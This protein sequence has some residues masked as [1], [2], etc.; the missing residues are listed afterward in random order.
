MFEVK[1]RDGLAR[2]AE[3]T[4]GEETVRLPCVMDT[5]ILFP[6]LANRSFSN[7]P[8]AAPESFVA[9][10]LTQSQDQPVTVHPAIPAKASSGDCVM[11]ANWNTILQNPRSY[12]EWLV[13]LKEQSP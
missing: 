8:L 5:E 7:V 4:R 10:Y 11:V 3:Y 6:D 12:T 2:I 1:K 9:T 13:R